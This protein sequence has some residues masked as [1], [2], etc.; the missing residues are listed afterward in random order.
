MSVE[1]GRQPLPIDAPVDPAVETALGTPAKRGNIYDRLA[2]AKEMTPAQR[3]KAEKDRART[4]ET[5]DLPE[6]LIEAV[7][8]VARKYSVPKSNVVAHL[9][10][11]GLRD[12]LEGRINLRWVRKIS[13][14]PRF[15]GL[16][17]S[18]EEIDKAEIERFCNGK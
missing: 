3:R 12:L 16:L 10:T 15:E 18:P 11:A 4:K 6:W 14:S 5:Y 9:L 17:E 1:K 2:R 13:R 8:Q 7:E